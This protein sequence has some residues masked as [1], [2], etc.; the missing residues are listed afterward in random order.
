MHPDVDTEKDF[1]EFFGKSK[2]EL[3]KG[4]VTYESNEVKRQIYNKIKPY[5]DE[6]ARKMYLTEEYD[7]MLLGGITDGWFSSIENSA[8]SKFDVE[9]YGEETIYRMALDLFNSRDIEILDYGCGSAI[10]SLNL[11]FMGFHNITLV[12]IPHRYFRFLKFLC[13]KYGIA[14]KFVPIEAEVASLGNIEFD[15]IICSNV[16]EHCWN[17]IRVLSFLVDHLKKGGWIYIS[18]FYNSCNGED[19]THL[20]HNEIYQDEDLKHRIYRSLGIE[21]VI[22]DKNGV[23]KGWRKNDEKRTIFPRKAEEN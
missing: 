7:A 11:Y 10:Y 14:L 13:S 18:D 15:Y 4:F 23:G 1:V 16:L 6:T 20:Y 17:P 21:L 9:A 2:A 5:N 19:P 8:R 12:D 3:L 22:Y